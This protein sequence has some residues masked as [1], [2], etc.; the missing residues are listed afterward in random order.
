V[1]KPPEPTSDK[2]IALFDALRKAT[3]PKAKKKKPK[4]KP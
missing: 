1:T 4:V 2:L 3:K